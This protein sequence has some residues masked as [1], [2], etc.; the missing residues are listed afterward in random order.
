MKWKI[1]ALL[2]SLLVLRLLLGRR[3]VLLCQM[4]GQV[5]ATFGQVGVEFERLQVQAD[6]HGRRQAL[7]EEVAQT[8]ELQLLALHRMQAA[9]HLVL[10]EARSERAE[11]EELRLPARRIDRGWH[12]HEDDAPQRPRR[13]RR[14]RQRLKQAHKAPA[15]QGLG[16]TPDFNNAVVNNCNQSTRDMGMC[17]LRIWLAVSC[18]ASMR[19]T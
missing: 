17:I 16:M 19:N 14:I 9:E 1:V 8:R 11:G 6:R 7:E 3:A 13:P 15:Y 12:E 5:L 2:A 18:P 4:F 10:A